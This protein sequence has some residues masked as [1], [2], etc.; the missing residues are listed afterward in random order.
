VGFFYFGAKDSFMERFFGRN[1]LED[2]CEEGSG[3]LLCTERFGKKKW[4]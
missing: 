4:M 1:I 3:E 2:F